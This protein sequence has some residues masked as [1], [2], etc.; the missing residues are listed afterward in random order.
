M[1]FYNEY[2]YPYLVDRLG[3]PAPIRKIR[4]QI[5]PQAHGNVLEIGAG[6]GTNFPYYDSTRVTRLY[7]LEP[8]RGMIQLAKKKRRMTLLDIAFL[9]L[10]GEQ[11][12]L[13]KGTMETIVS[14]FTLCTIPGIVD[15]IQGLARILKPNGKLI[16]LDLGFLPTVL[17]NA[18]KR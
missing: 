9:D 10:P 8:N 13:G 11:I 5:I 3:D 1:R 12:P 17:Y 4:Q 6:S 2:V 14:T 16:F 7:A 15:A 18:G